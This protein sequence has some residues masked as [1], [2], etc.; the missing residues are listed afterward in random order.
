MNILFVNATH[1]WAGIKTWMLELGTFLARRGHQV[2]FACHDGDQL[3]LECISR[4]LTCY[5]GRFGMDFSPRAIGWFLSIFQAEGTEVI[6]TNIA[7]D[8]RTAG[9]AAKM[10]GIAHINRLGNFGDIHETL[11]TQL[12]YSSCVDKVFVPARALY[13]HFENFAFLRG[14][15]RHFPNAVNPPPLRLE[16]HAQTQ[17]AIVANL[18]KRKQVDRVLQV[19]QQLRDLPWELHIGGDGPELENLQALT[20]ELQ[21]AERVHFANTAVTPAHASFRRVNPYEF[22]KG[23]D[24]GL[25]YSTQEGF[26]YALVE[27][28][29]M[30]CAVIASDLPGVREL[31]QPGVN[32]LL[33]DPQQPDTLAAALRA[34]IQ[35]NQQRESLIRNGHKIVQRQFHQ[36]VIFPRVE[37]E[38]LQTITR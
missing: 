33:V 29:A 16:S 32:G 8:I 3:L 38:I 18:T 15:V 10:R 19:F 1:G 25:L 28:M 35:N 9:I 21:L 36:D 14:K 13:E 12:L 26:P 17:F 7:K 4:G 34:M 27:Y 5:S 30:S 23:K 22:L 2:A 11:K 20:Q 24:V 6:I 37:K 31:V